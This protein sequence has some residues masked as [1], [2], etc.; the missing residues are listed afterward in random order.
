MGFQALRVLVLWPL[1]PSQCDVASS[2]T[3][4]LELSALQS[5]RAQNQGHS[6]VMEGSSQQFRCTEKS[7]ENTIGSGKRRA[8]E[9]RARE[10]NRTEAGSNAAGMKQGGETRIREEWW[11]CECC[12]LRCNGV[13]GEDKEVLLAEPLL[14][15]VGH[16]RVLRCALG[17]PLMQD[18]VQCACVWL[19]A[20]EAVVE[21]AADAIR[22]CRLWRRWD[23]E[24]R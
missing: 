3:K 11:W 2:E 8:R 16:F 17:A 7:I 13:V 6:C 5:I 20:V 14:G 18:D 15:Q 22:H 24:V 9:E 23:L 21:Q 1:A 4:G 19:P 10:K 12:V